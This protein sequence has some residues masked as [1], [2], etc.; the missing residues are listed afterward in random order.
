[1]AGLPTSE[2]KKLIT[3]Y[4]SLDEVEELLD[5]EKFFRANRQF[6]IQLRSIDTM[7][8]DESGKIMVKMKMPHSPEVVVSK[9]KAAVF[10]KWIEG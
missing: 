9:E 1:M 5:P 7:R 8:S 10:R 3:D 6:I 4:R 2:G